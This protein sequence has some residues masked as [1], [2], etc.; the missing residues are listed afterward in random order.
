MRIRRLLAWAMALTAVAQAAAAMPRVMTC[1]RELRGKEA[2]CRDMKAH[3]IDAVEFGCR[4]VPECR[5]MLKAVR[6]AG[7][8]IST[9]IC[10]LTEQAGQ[11]LELGVEPEYAVMIGGAYRGQAI[12]RH[13]FAFPAAKH[14]II[15][16]PPINHRGFPYKLGTTGMDGKKGS[17]PMGHYY[18]GV[19]PIRAE[20]VVPLHDY[21]GKQH[22]K[23]VPARVEEAQTGANPEV[24]SVS[25]A[26]YFSCSE[27]RNR[28]L[29]RVAFDL[30]GL[31][32]AMLNKVGV[33]VYW[34]MENPGPGY[35][36]FGRGMAS[37]AS[38][39]TRKALL[40]EIDRR[41]AMWNE[42][43][44]GEFPSG[45]LAAFRFG[46]ESFLRTGDTSGS[47]APSYPLW[48]FS[49]SG[50]AAFKAL[51]PEGLEHPRTWGHPE[52]YGAE[53]YGLWQYAF[54]KS[55]AELVRIVRRKL[56]AYAPDAPLYRNTTRNPVFYL[57]NDHDGTGQELLAK[58]L[59]CVHLDPYPAGPVYQT[60][61]IAM[62]MGYC[63]GLSRRFA[64]P[65]VPWMQ[66]HVYGSLQHVTPE[67]VERMALE[68][69]RH[70]IDGVIWLGYGS[71]P[72]TFPDS[73]RASWEAA[74]AF[75]RRLRETRSS[76]PVAELAALRFYN[77]WAVSSAE[78]AS[79]VR[80]PA[81]WMLQQFLL[82]WSCD[83]GLA[84][85][86][87]EVPPAMTDEERTALTK[88]V[89]RYRFVVANASFPG[90]KVVGGGTQG[91][92]VDVRE[93]DA[94]RARFRGE[95]SAMLS[96]SR[97][98][99]GFRAALPVWP[100]G[101]SKTLN[102]F[103]TFRAG[104]D[105]KEGDDVRLRATAG[106]VY[107][108]RLNGEF[109]AFGPARATPGFFRVDEWR[110]TPR[111]GGNTIEIDVAGYNC[112]N[113]YLAKQ[114]PFLQAELLVNGKVVAA[115]GKGSFSAFATGKLRK[116]PRYAYQRP[117][118]E[119]YR[120]PSA[121][122]APLRLVLQSAKK[123]L[124]RE[125]DVPMF[126]VVQAEP[127]SRERT[128]RDADV[129]PAVPRFLEGGLGNFVCFPVDELEDNPYFEMQ[130]RK[131]ISREK[132]DA[133]KCGRFSLDDGDGV[134]FELDRV[135]GGFPGL[136][137]R[138]ETPTTI[139]LTYDEII[140]EDGSVDFVRTDTM[141]TLT[142]HLAEPG[143]YAL[144]SFEPYGCKYMR[145][146]SVGGRATVSAPYVRTYESP[147]AERAKFRS[148]DPALDKIFDAA[149]ASYAANAV[150]CLTDCPNRERGGW[151][152]D[153]FFTGRASQLLTGSGRNEKL[154]L[155]NFSRAERFPAPKRYEGLVPA[156]WPCDLMCRE[157]FIPTYDMWLV[158]ELEECVSRNGYA[159]L[160]DS[161]RPKVDGLLDYLGRYVN[162]YGLLQHLPGWV[163]IE[164]SDANTLVYDV[165]YPA[166][167]L[168]AWSLD[169]AA[170]MYG[171]RDMAQ[172]A[173]E[174]RERVRRESFDGM[175]FCDN[176]VVKDRVGSLG[177][178]GRH[179]E[180]CQY[181]AFF[182]GTA[183]RQT[184]P[185]L[186]RRLMEDF[187]PN[188]I[189]K[190]LYPEVA[191]ANF[192]FGTLLRMELLS[193]DGRAGQMYEE[194]RDYLLYMA[195]RTGSLWENQ[196][197]T[198]SCCHGFAS[199]AAVYLY[200]D[201]LG[202]RDVDYLGKCVTLRPP[203]DVPLDWC[204]GVVPLSERAVAE[205]SWRRRPDG[206]VSVATRLPE[207]W[208]VR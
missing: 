189:K 197:P 84:Y 51:A 156:I 129:K 40:L 181:F 60:D 52:I 192:L 144:E 5:A 94:Y 29:Y 141:A 179:T 9:G 131:A 95:I 72:Y 113:F 207:D 89:S 195:E 70:G 146:L 53:A 93:A 124:P 108:A 24:D 198:A 137:V 49:A 132:I 63:S 172:K 6:A 83:R 105:A 64:K 161:F 158:G 18:P 134:V 152:G 23:I 39:K 101:E 30:S 191:P 1:Y 121:A 58:E 169:A 204:E 50:I 154:F 106:Y 143:D 44:G 87:F 136:S 35:E 21:D 202:V 47:P 116:T 28:K 183:T 3:G 22:L 103:F 168:Y 194:L 97:E 147:S 127:V 38:A 17:E 107:K 190:G 73:N 92:V 90:A 80:N 25:D 78:G 118:S 66:A 109:A 164:W 102:A 120:I 81:D 139:Y 41:M 96:E 182:T 37:P 75:H 62:D 98:T 155:E 150:D 86:V 26:A 187:G 138:A 69:W 167:M 45:A 8:K 91:A 67:L 170:R 175:W 4:G 19:V 128:R 10:D 110:L 34:R 48:D 82:A 71:A 173:S 33:A 130:R 32:D 74:A 200:R 177:P 151:L 36:G 148:S 140:Q 186:Y 14:A 68:N 157:C 153:T 117:Y 99:A 162:D 56:D 199:I 165:N 104:F 11:M 125:W 100:E 196:Q 57:S 205:I 79:G 7:L 178:S 126:D 122:G 176:A 145:V 203:K 12:D 119:V 13:L 159:G 123:L 61:R 15:I 149:K 65:L 59:D 54:H 43:N 185:E 193:R 208:R 180:V 76:K 188:R 160:V 55:C 135:R 20:V 163:F 174:V 88:T 111:N 142:W 77:A 31:D 114:T 42:A 166:N 133:A 206:G 46:D 27:Y 184:H 2:D 85:D 115:T 171:R 112:P 201:I 16:E